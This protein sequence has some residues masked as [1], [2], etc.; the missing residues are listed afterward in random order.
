M[1]ISSC[2]TVTGSREGIGSRS[3]QTKAFFFCYALVLK[4]NQIMGI[5]KLQKKRF[6]YDQYVQ[7]RDEWHF[8]A[9]IRSHFS[10]IQILSADWSAVHIL[11][12]LIF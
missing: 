9:A 3:I 11:F 8:Q 1:L 5:V 7:M 10:V 6:S 4:V 12:L 2:Y